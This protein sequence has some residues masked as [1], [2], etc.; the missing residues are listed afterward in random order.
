MNRL[1]VPLLVLGL[2]LA[3]AVMAAVLGAAAP[4]LGVDPVWGAAL[5]VV[6][7]ASLAVGVAWGARGARHAGELGGAGRFQRLGSRVAAGE[8]GPDGRA[9]PIT[10]RTAAAM[11]DFERRQH[12]P[13]ASLS[14]LRGFGEGLEG[15]GATNWEINYFSQA[16]R[17]LLRLQAVREGGGYRVT[18]EMENIGV[19]LDTM[20]PDQR[21]AAWEGLLL[22]NQEVAPD[23]A[24][25]PAVAQAVAAVSHG[26]DADAPPPRIRQM[27]VAMAR[28]TL[29]WAPTIF[30][31]VEAEEGNELYRYYCD[32]QTTEVLRREQLIA[33]PARPS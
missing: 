24:D 26:L 19:W 28:P 16:G 6:A 5:G 23:Y 8:R 32:I 12:V 27:T 9:A 14:Y 10:A 3:T 18:A 1:K 11:T 22:R 2:I 33:A 7:G 21:D 20:G 13:G 30:W 31:I 4:L 15:G 17:K 29:E 25:S